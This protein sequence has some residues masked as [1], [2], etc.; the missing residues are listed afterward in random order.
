MATPNTLAV[1]SG[2]GRAGSDQWLMHLAPR[3][4]VHLGDLEADPAG[5]G[6]HP[7]VVRVDDRTFQAALS[8]PAGARAM[9]DSIVAARAQHEVLARS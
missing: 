6:S 5:E 7:L 2:G 4:A 8:G 1:I 9:R 3:D